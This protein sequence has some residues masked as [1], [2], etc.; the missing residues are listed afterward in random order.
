MGNYGATRTYLKSVFKIFAA[1]IAPVTELKYFAH[2]PA[3]SLL[4]LFHVSFQSGRSLSLWQKDNTCHKKGRERQVTQ[5]TQ[6]VRLL[7]GGAGQSGKCGQRAVAEGS[8]GHS[9]QHALVDGVGLFP[10]LLVKQSL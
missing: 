2:N 10:V 6:G 5:R 7:W 8:P 9:D 1:L 4:S 3:T